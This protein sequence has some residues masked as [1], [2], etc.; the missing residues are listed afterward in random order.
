MKDPYIGGAYTSRR[1][2]QFNISFGK[3]SQ[4]PFTRHID[5]THMTN[6]L[7][8]FNTTGSPISYASGDL[9]KASVWMFTLMVAN[10]ITRPRIIGGII[11]D[12][13]I[14]LIQ[15]DPANLLHLSEF[16]AIFINTKP[17]HIISVGGMRT[18]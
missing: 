6:G 14:L 4:F 17:T 10:G 18:K 5:K 13:Y 7:V 15:S 9:V 1:T 8:Y 2:A 3:G 12:F 11:L 16:T